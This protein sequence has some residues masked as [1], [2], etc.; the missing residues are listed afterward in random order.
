MEN[1]AT[2][3]AGFLFDFL[4]TKH[5]NGIERRGRRKAKSRII[6]S[7]TYTLDIVNMRRM[8]KKRNPRIAAVTNCGNAPP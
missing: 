6:F 2:I 5:K 7:L 4:S 3:K 8:L 1:T